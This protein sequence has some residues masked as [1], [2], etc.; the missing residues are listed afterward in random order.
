MRT[1]HVFS[2]VIL[3][4]SATAS[5]QQLTDAEKKEGFESLF[6][7]K[8]FTG[9]RFNSGKGDNWEVKDGLLVLKGGS[10]HL[11]SEKEY[12]DFTIRFEW[13]AEKKG[14]DSGFYI[15]SGMKVGANQ[16]QL[17]QGG[18]GSIGGVQGAK[19]VPKMH[20]APGEWNSWEVTCVGDKVTFVVNDEKAWEGTGLKPARG[21]FGIQAEG[22][23][24]DFRNFRI[25]EI[26]S[27]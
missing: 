9:W 5:A 11:A 27:K 3:L 8:D 22:H 20:K 14:Y 12:G 15:R 6:N 2:T 4:W 23:H 7:A 13:R 25:K 21:Y 26:K 16:I 19:A 24:I 1:A 10:D 17:G 18:E